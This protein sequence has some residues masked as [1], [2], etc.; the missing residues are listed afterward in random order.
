M[1]EAIKWAT[2]TGQVTY[3]R[4]KPIVSADEDLRSEIE[5]SIK[6]S[7]IRYDTVYL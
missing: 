7:K 2:Y 1:M 5:T 3:G 6:A 4:Q